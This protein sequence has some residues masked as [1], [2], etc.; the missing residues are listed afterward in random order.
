MAPLLSPYGDGRYQVRW[1]ESGKI[2]SRVFDTAADARRFHAMRA[3]EP[4]TPSIDVV[5]A[6]W[7]ADGRHATSTRKRIAHTCEQLLR[8]FFGDTPIESITPDQVCRWVDWLHRERQYS[9]STIRQHFC[10]LRAAMG[11]A[12]DALILS[13]NPCAQVA[14]PR[15][16]KSQRAMALTRLNKPRS[17]ARRAPGHHRDCAPLAD[18][19]R[20]L[21]GTAT[22]EELTGFLRGLDI[23][24]DLD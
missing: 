21:A 22:A 10:V 9:A 5:V 17:A 18:L 14:L 6:K 24:T 15:V 16:P 19:R 23:A 7:A 2:R 11:W 8:P 3:Q 12:V 20:A 13:V 1:D 4:I